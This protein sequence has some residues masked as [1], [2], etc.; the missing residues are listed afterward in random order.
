LLIQCCTGRNIADITG[1]DNGAIFYN[2]KRTGN[3]STKELVRAVKLI[4]RT[5]DD[6]KSGHID[7]VYATEYILVSLL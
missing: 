2:K 5:V 7:D 6:I 4:S 3:Y 1:L